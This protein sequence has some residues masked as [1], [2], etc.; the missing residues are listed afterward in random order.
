[1]KFHIIVAM[2]AVIG[3]L[4]AVAIVSG[5]SHPKATGGVGWFAAGLD[6]SASFNAHGTVPAKGQFNYHD[7]AGNFIKATVVCYNQTGD[8]DAVFT[9]E[10]SD[11]NLAVYA[12]AGFVK[13]TVHDG[14]TPGRN[15]DTI[16]NVAVTTDDCSTPTAG[17]FAVDNGNLVVH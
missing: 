7:E 14:G 10:V 6:R 3:A 2:V 13:T 1:M 4:A 12:A 5:A 8:D 15:G 16:R 17:G 11:T 9:S